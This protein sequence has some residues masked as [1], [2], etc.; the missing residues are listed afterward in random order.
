MNSFSE[1]PN[2]PPIPTDLP[3]PDLQPQSFAQVGQGVADGLKADGWWDGVWRSLAEWAAIIAGNIIKVAVQGIAPIM[4]FLVKTWV[5]ANKGLDAS[6]QEMAKDSVQGIFDVQVGASQFASLEGRDS[7][8]PIGK[9]IGDAIF[10]ALT[11]ETAAGQTT[12]IQPSSDQAEKWVTTMTN[13]AMEEWLTDFVGE[14]LSAGFIKDAGELRGTLV[15]N[16]GLGR[17]SRRILSPIVDALVVTPFEWKINKAYRH[18]LLSPTDAVRQFLR[19]KWTRAQ[20]DEECGRAGLSPDRIDAIINLGVKR[21]GDSDLSTLVQAGSITL[22]AAQQYLVDSGY[23]TLTAAWVLQVNEINFVRSLEHAYLAEFTTAY[24]NREIDI[25]TYT[26]ALNNSGLAP[27]EIEFQGRIATAKR[28]FNIQHLSLAQEINLVKDG[29]RNIGD[30]SDATTRMGY[31]I[32]DARDL[33]LQVLLQM[34]QASNKAATLADAKKAQ[35]AAKLV[36]DAAAAAKAAAA[37]AKVANA[38]LSTAKFEALV[39]AGIRTLAEYRAFLISEGTKAGDAADLTTLLQN[40]IADAKL[41]ADAKAANDTHATTKGASLPQ[42]QKAVIDGILSIAEYTQQLRNLGY[43]VDAITLLTEEMTRDLSDQKARDDAHTAALAAAADKGVSITA[44][45]RAVKLGIRTV[46]DYAAFLSSLGYGPD[47]VSLLADSLDRELSNEDDARKLKEK[48]TADAAAK[49]L[50]LPELEKAV[51]AGV[52]NI[53]DYRDAL[54]KLGY[55]ADA[56]AALVQLLQLQMDQDQQTLALQGSASALLGQRGISLVQVARGVELGLLDIGT[57]TDTLIDSG[58][59]QEDA[60]YLTL[61]EAS[62]VATQKAAI[63]KTKSASALLT[64]RGLSLASLESDVKAKRLTI[65]AFASQLA[66]AGVEAADIQTLT[67]V[68]TQELQAIDD[69]EAT[70]AQSAGKTT[71]KGL[72]LAQGEKAVREG[73]ATLDDYYAIALELGY[74]PANAELLT[75]TLGAQIDTSEQ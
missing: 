45:E 56:Q 28:Q 53:T 14:M 51:R 22:A 10:K 65:T 58:M 5:I 24:V 42:I 25:S 9:N 3:F 2:I 19:G 55:D 12:G 36:K 66:Q 59:T 68:L 43:S 33:E 44:F 23:D 16:L 37:A 31:S 41:V 11:G 13:M 74:S 60:D 1:Q 21:I 30:L 71:A 38:G 8:A 61:I 46:D 72:S 32:T 69:A 20:L 18:K 54:V 6:M 57:Y 34:Q 15:K 35:A 29:I 52:R 64:A 73:T 40:Q 39:R 62:K 50:S 4:V 63:D 49:G 7:R 70:K 27:Q 26:E 17:V 67:D 47:D 48:A 75:N